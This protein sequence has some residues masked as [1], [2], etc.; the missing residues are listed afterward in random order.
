MPH[1]EALVHQHGP[2]I[3]RV[4][5]ALLPEQDAGDGWSETFL[6]V[7]RHWSAVAAADNVQAYLVRIAQR[8]CADIGKRSARHIP[9]AQLPEQAVTDGYSRT[10]LWQALARLPVRQR[11]A[12]IFHHL[13]GLPFSEVASALE[14]TP[15][16][17]RRA[18]AD[19]IATLRQ[20]WSFEELS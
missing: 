10:E 5:R 17:A 19:G 13:A 2:M 11:Q 8:A 7:L 6:A 18:S 15:T 3:W 16:A 14:T 20:R 4:C 1:F 9:M 12:V